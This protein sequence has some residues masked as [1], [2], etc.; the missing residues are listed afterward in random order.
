MS[1]PPVKPKILGLILAGGG[2]RRFGTDKATALL[3]GVSLIERVAERA[4]PQVDTLL[5]NRND[6]WPPDTP[7]PYPILRDAIPG[8]GPLSGIVAG[9][10]Y[11][12]ARGFSH[13]ATF[14]CDTP[15]FPR[16]CV[17]RLLAASVDDRATVCV[18]SG[19]RALHPTFALVH[20]NG[21]P[22]VIAAFASGIRSLHE[23]AR[24]VGALEV[25]FPSSSDAPDG[26][27]FFNINAPIDMDRANRWLSQSKCRAKAKSSSR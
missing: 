7:L 15:F 8:E 19:G 16:D 3:A 11:G 23:A 5:I 9:L 1:A 18:A 4:A 17:A 21:A 20:A 13:L 12:A 2:S 14:S 25:Q 10:H 6:D 24:V 27:G 26:D 22:A